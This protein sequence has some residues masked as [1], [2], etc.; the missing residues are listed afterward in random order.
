MISSSALLYIG[1]CA[2]MG[3]VCG[4]LVR[5]QLKAE[6]KGPPYHKAWLIYIIGMALCF[7]IAESIYEVK[8]SR[9]LSESDKWL[10]VTA[11]PLFFFG[12]IWYWRINKG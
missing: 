3:A 10:G 12:S 4:Y 1:L 2:A 11:V 5:Y 7:A 6:K 8:T 9:F